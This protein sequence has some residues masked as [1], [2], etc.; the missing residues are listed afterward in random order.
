MVSIL[1]PQARIPKGKAYSSR[2][3]ACFGCMRL[4]VHDVI[5]NPRRRISS[6]KDALSTTA[7]GLLGRAEI[8]YGY[9]FPFAYGFFEPFCFCEPRKPWNSRG[10]TGLGWKNQDRGSCLDSNRLSP[11][12]AVLY[13]KSG[14]SAYIS[15][16]AQAFQ[17][18]CSAY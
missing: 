5:E 7:F 2:N 1:D 11:A 12:G 4:W 16:T 3:D 14:P 18:R 9:S 10:R 8:P 17:E 15:R 6:N 13:V